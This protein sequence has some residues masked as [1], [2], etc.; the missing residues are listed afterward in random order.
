MFEAGT[1]DPNLG[2]IAFSE[3]AITTNQVIV[4]VNTNGQVTLQAHFQNILSNAIQIEVDVEGYYS[5]TGGSAFL[6]VSPVLIGSSTCASPPTF[7]TLTSPTAADTLKFP[8]SESYN[9]SNSQDTQ[10]T[11]TSLPSP[12][13]DASAIS[14]VVLNV[15]AM[16]NSASG[17]LSIYPADLSSSGVSSTGYE[18]GTNAT[19]EAIVQFP[20][21]GTY[22]DEVA[23]SSTSA[24]LSYPTNVSADIVGYFVSQPSTNTYFAVSPTRICDTRSSSSSN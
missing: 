9:Y 13:S 17:S 15:T 18:S 21:G 20:E 24:S 14:A 8:V 11:G 16:P 1:S 19:T 22:T 7:T 12:I 23:I 4:P 5:I 10:F 2:N 6:P 3:G